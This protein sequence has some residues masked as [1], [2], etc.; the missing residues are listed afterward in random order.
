MARPTYLLYSSLSKQ[1]WLTDSDQQG[2]IGSLTARAFLG[3]HSIFFGPGDFVSRAAI[4]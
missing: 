4:T 2:V 1:P 3:N